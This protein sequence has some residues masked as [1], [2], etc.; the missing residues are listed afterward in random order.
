[1]TWS[2]L[3]CHRRSPTVSMSGSAVLPRPPLRVSRRDYTKWLWLY[4]HQSPHL[5]HARAP[6]ATRTRGWRELPPW[7]HT[8]V[9]AWSGHLTATPGRCPSHSGCNEGGDGCP[10][11]TSMAYRSGYRARPAR[12]ERPVSRRPAATFPTGFGAKPGPVPGKPLTPGPGH[13]ATG[14]ESDT[15]REAIQRSPPAA[16]GPGR[17]PGATSGPIGGGWPVFCARSCRAGSPGSRRA[18]QMGPSGC[19]QAP[20]RPP[21]HVPP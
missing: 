21:L 18:R 3:L 4:P 19:A 16:R 15:G 9:R 2:S 11:L 6:W 5:G 14:A 20:A 13:A 7:L 1:M 8:G 12:R 17:P 10:A